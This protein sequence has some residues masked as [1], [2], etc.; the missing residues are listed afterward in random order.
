LRA[1][2]RAEAAAL[3]GALEIDALAQRL[4]P[5][6]QGAAPSDALD[7]APPEPAA[8]AP[9]PPTATAPAAP[10][11]PAG[12]T[13]ATPLASPTLLPIALGTIVAAGA[14]IAAWW[15]EAPAPSIA[16]AQALPSWVGEA[17]F[18]PPPV[19]V[20]V[21]AELDPPADIPEQERD[22]APPPPRSRT[23]PPPPGQPPA[24]PA[25]QLEDELR[26]LSRARRALATDPAQALA[27]TRTH[28]ASFTAGRLA[29]EREL[30]AITALLALGRAGDA[31][32]RARVF[33]AAHP[34][35]PHL[36]RVDSLLDDESD[37]KNQR[38]DPFTGSE[39]APE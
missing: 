7:P 27:L 19:A 1:A 37:R 5:L 18:I 20:A 24:P 29:E 14:M 21:R 30:I 13:P 15:S 3:P 10:L 23:N 25:M 34:A 32:A 8:P 22:G 39:E 16:L 4:G 17:S 2:L 36:R 6:L 26:L 33:R 9:G 38:A 35:S 11:L 28:A 31:D 12:S